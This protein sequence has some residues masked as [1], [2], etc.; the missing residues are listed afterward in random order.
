MNDRPLASIVIPTYQAERTLGATISSALPQTY[1]DVEVVVCIDGATDASAAIAQSYGDRITVIT[2]ENRGLP[3]ARNA[4]IEAARGDLVALL[5]AD[6]LLLPPY[7]ERAVAR[8]QRAGGGRRFVTC[9][10]TF[11]GRQGLLTDRSI[12]PSPREDLKRQRMLMLE[13]NIATIFSVFPRAM[14]VELGGFDTELTAMEDYH[15]WARAVLSGWELHFVREADAIYRLTPGSVSSRTDLM[16]ENNAEV[17]RRLRSEFGASLSAAERD[18]L[19][20]TLTK[21][22]SGYSTERAAEALAAGD[23]AEAARLCQ[24]AADV[25]PSV[26]SLQ[27]KA[28]LLR[29]VPATG[30]VYRMREQRRLAATSR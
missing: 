22:W 2:Q 10:A 17:R 26:R 4:A 20:M 9:N 1:P 18:F 23:V 12:I 7:I 29:R 27:L 24:E 25:S 8:W 5:D 19:D 15:F 21:D 16:N 11:M 30:S 28:T 3:G 6:D 14:W 13:T